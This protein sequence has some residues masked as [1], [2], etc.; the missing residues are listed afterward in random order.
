MLIGIDASR[1]FLKKRTGIEEYAYQVI[2]HLRFQLPEDVCVVL[3][4]R[5]DQDVTFDLPKQ[6]RVKKMWAPR[7]W[8]QARLSL[9]MFFHRPDILF[10]PAHTVPIIHPQK[11]IVTIHG[12]EYEFCKEAYSLWERWYMRLSI[13]FSCRAAEMVVCV[14]E[15]TKQDVM[16]LYNVAEKKIQVIHEGFE[17]HGIMNQS[18]TLSTD[19]PYFLFIG[20]LEERKNIVRVIEAFETLKERYRI[21][22]KLLLVG[23]P[24]Y[25]Y[26]R[27]KKK[28]T[29]SKY[30]DMIVEKGYVSEEEKWN[31][32]KNADIFLFP[33][34]YEGFG[35]PVLEAQSMRIP[36]VT[37]KVS[38]LPEISGEGAILVDPGDVESIVEGTHRLFSDQGIRDD[39]IEKGVDNVHR[40][41]WKRCARDLAVF[42]S[43]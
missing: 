13:W 34:L 12:L 31:L 14:S 28:I 38:S 9:E 15:N 18:G 19:I 43:Q 5:S 24:G 8:T 3:Y 26:E 20:R 11:T 42:F 25:G 35:I 33:T 36:V 41:G 37:S 40:F 10:V 7:L 4:I 22:Q 29:E 23:K 6:W 39:I 2:R 16:R 21:P 1:A 27:I 17:E 30:Q 32:L